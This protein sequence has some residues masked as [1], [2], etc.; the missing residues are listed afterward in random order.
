MSKLPSA[1]ESKSSKDEEE[2]DEEEE[3]D[4]EEEM[5]IETSHDAAKALKLTLIKL[6]E[7]LVVVARKAD[8]IS[9]K[10]NSSIDFKTLMAS[11][12]K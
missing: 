8:E 4:E 11:F 10:K 5:P 12:A 3:G 7:D 2:D 1:K 6:T 9:G